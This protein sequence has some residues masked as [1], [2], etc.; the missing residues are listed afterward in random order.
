MTAAQKRRLTHRLRRFLLLG[1]V[2][3][4][5]YLVGFAAAATL[6]GEQDTTQPAEIIVVLGSGLKE[7][8]RPGPALTR[9][10]RQGA[11]L[12]HTG[13]APLI[14]CTGGQSEYF[15]RTEAAA[16][17][18]ILLAAG[19]PAVA[20]LLEVRSRSTE[21]NAIYSKQLLDRL[22]LSRIVLVSDS[23]HMLR[24]RWLFQ[25]QGIDPFASPVPADRLRDWRVYPA[26]LIREF[27][28][29]NWQL[30]KDLFGIPWT[31]VKGI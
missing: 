30:F 19:V 1:L 6:I 15:P 12:W 21:E 2:A 20:I 13:V 29:F 31:H 24:A 5:G 9:R 11:A 4:V 10:S 23:F 22:G 18:E 25:K 26:A 3:L 27:I 8:G 17:R 16:C 7:D 14:M 28:A